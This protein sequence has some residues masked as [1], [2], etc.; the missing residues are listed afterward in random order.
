MYSFNVQMNNFDCL[1]IPSA[2]SYTIFGNSNLSQTLK[3]QDCLGN[4][5]RD[6]E[7]PL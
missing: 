7:L 4:K 1:N 6:S 2:V 5:D 3:P